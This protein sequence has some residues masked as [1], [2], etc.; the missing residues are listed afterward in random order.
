VRIS[1]TYPSTD[2][3]EVIV[4]E[5]ATGAGELWEPVGYLATDESSMENH[6][7]TPMTLYRY[8]AY[9]RSAS[10][11][12]TPDS[13]QATI[14]TRPYVPGYAV[15]DLA[16]SL[17][18]DD[19]VTPISARLKRQR[20]R[21][22]MTVGNHLRQVGNASPLDLGLTAPFGL[23]D[24]NEVLLMDP[25]GTANRMTFLWRPFAA[26]LEFD[27]GTFEPYRLTDPGAI[28]GANLVQVQD[29]QGQTIHTVGA[30]AYH[31]WMR[32][33]TPH[34]PGQG[35]SVPPSQDRPVSS[36]SPA[37]AR[38]LRTAHPNRSHRPRP[39][40]VAG[41]DFPSRRV[42]KLC[43]LSAHRQYEQG[44]R[45]GRCHGLMQHMARFSPSFTKHL[46]PQEIP[47]VTN[48]RHPLP[49]SRR[50]RIGARGVNSSV[51]RSYG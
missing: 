11:E 34:P 33:M 20:H 6:G 2:A 24:N 30:Y 26:A 29:S 10:G 50:F 8:R 49:Q 44:F 14:T 25:F 45:M 41:P 5:R 9:V 38:R 17:V 13:N 22:L 21:D 48:R 4:V 19:L 7:L 32:A 16:E 51:S 39:S 40:A 47:R 31:F 1:W 27:R 3:N 37:Q 28:V 35:R 18:D 12:R 42:A 36:A 23:S 15:L 43:L 46:S